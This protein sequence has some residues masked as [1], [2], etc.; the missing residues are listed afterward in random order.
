MLVNHDKVL[1]CMFAFFGPNRTQNTSF[2]WAN[3]RKC[4]W[5][6]ILA[7]R[8]CAKQKIVLGC[9]PF[10]INLHIFVSC[11]EVFHASYYQSTVVTLLGVNVFVFLG[12]S[13]STQYHYKNRFFTG[14][15]VNLSVPAILFHEEAEKTVRRDVQLWQPWFTEHSQSEN[16]FLWRAL[17]S[18]PRKLSLRA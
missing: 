13:G 1:R 7:K 5:F 10:S 6:A 8:V 9:G 3:Q 17:I 15:M 18:F 14:A 16:T 2:W 4:L 12:P 11:F